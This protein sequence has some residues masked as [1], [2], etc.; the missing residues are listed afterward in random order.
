MSGTVDDVLRVARGEIGCTNG[1][2]YFNHFGQSDLGPW[3]VAW[4][5]YCMDVAGGSFDWH[6]WYAWDWTD[7]PNPISP[8]NLRAGDALSFDWDGDNLGDHVGIVESVHDW[9]CK[10]IEGNTSGGVCAKKDRGWDC[11]ICGIRPNYSGSGAIEVDGWAGPRTVAAWQRAMG[12]EAD[13]TISDQI[14][15][16]DQYRERVV[17][18]DHYPYDE[19]R[20]GY[21]GS[22]LVRAVQ[23]RV[24]AGVDGDWGR[25]TSRMV[26]TRLKSLGYYGDAIDGYFGY[27]ST[28][29]LQRSL[30]DGK[31]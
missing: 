27:N 21:Q 19:A 13:G 24:G 9:G 11:I 29:A 3:C 1:A 7:A 22:A 31:W 28:V 14:R 4:V 25:E 15:S 10:T 26:Q 12:T 8:R 16:N 30:N 5:R 6:T 17:A 18:I 2:K 20:S 23:G